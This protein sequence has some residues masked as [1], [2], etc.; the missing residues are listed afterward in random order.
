LIA[1]NKTTAN[2]INSDGWKFVIPSDI[3]RLAPF[4]PL[5]TPGIKTKINMMNAKAK[6]AGAKR[7]QTLRGTLNAR[8]PTVKAIIIEI[9]CLIKK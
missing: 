9:A 4:T 2:F 6:M 8:T 3:Q 1:A 7:S 5:P